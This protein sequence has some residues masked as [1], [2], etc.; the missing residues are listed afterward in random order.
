MWERAFSDICIAAV[1]SVVI[2][3]LILKDRGEGIVWECVFQRH[4]HVVD[5]GLKLILLGTKSFFLWGGVIR[6][7]LHTRK[8]FL[9]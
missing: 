6:K 2:C 9:L 3:I 4:L 7:D 5:D 8:S 1:A